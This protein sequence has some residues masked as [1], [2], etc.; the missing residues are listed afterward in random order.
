MTIEYYKKSI[1]CTNNNI[2]EEFGSNINFEQI[3]TFARSYL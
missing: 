1:Q 2:L 3:Q